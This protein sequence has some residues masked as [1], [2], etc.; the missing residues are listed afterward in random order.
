MPLQLPLVSQKLDDLVSN[1]CGVHDAI[2]SGKLLETWGS[3]SLVWRMFLGVL[4]TD[5]SKPPD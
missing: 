1:I 5:Q 4:P 2:E 3:R